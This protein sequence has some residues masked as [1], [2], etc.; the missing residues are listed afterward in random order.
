MVKNLIGPPVTGE[1][2]VGR[3]TETEQAMTYKITDKLGGFS[4]IYRKS[5]SKGL[6]LSNFSKSLTFHWTTRNIE[7][8]TIR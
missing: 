7:G 5:N 2:F 1:D 4:E 3:V 6:E 8:W